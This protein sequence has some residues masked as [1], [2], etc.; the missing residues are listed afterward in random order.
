MMMV[1]DIYLIESLTWIFKPDT[2]YRMTIYQLYYV[3]GHARSHT[4]NFVQGI[5]GDRTTLETPPYHT[6]SL[7]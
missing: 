3:N 6:I 4:H 1:G 5:M 2:A 7:I